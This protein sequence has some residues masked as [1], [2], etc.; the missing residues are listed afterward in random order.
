[1]SQT[2]IFN[3]SQQQKVHVEYS[4][5]GEDCFSESIVRGVCHFE[6][7]LALNKYTLFAYVS[8]SLDTRLC[9]SSCSL[10]V[11]VNVVFGS[12]RKG[13]CPQWLLLRLALG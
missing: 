3:P 5:C 10:N 8:M 4:T 6:C 12:L 9:V 7:H 13:E 11:S 2:S 1:M